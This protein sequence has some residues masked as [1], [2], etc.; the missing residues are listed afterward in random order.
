MA[1]GKNLVPVSEV[2]DA[3]DRKILHT[4]FFK[5]QDTIIQ[6]VLGRKS[7]KKFTVTDEKYSVSV[8]LL[9]VKN[10]VIRI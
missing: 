9:T 5:V 8:R 4:D 3:R 10:A 2:K 1:S 6:V 7:M